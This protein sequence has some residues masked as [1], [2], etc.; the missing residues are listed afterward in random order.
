M[1]K[2]IIFDA[3][4]TLYGVRTERAYK[5]AAD[6]LETRTGVKADKILTEWKKTI[7]KINFFIPDARDPQKRDRRY[8]LKKTLEALELQGKNTDKIVGEALDIFWRMAIEDLE[9]SPFCL[10]AVKELNKEYVLAVV[11]EE[12]K[13][14]LVRKINQAFSSWEKYFKFLITPEDTGAMKPSEKYYIEAMKKLNLFPS[15]I[16]AVGD[17]EERDIAPAKKLGIKT[18]IFN[19]K[20]AESLLEKV[21]KLI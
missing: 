16:L 6:F 5:A 9:V 11:S 12:F 21:N 15:E 7:D 17:S 1:I 14:N 4:G 10:S 19:F 8:A 18:L 3:D 2:A 13:K 20:E